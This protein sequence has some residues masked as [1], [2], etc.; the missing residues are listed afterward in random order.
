[1][2]A[3]LVAKDGFH[4]ILLAQ[5]HLAF[6]G[7]NRSNETNNTVLVFAESIGSIKPSPIA[8]RPLEAHR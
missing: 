1:M 6:S 2:T 5:Q 4:A 8:K 7:R 3:I